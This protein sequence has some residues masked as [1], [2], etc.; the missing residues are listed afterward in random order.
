M[1]KH[2]WQEREWKRHFVLRGVD[3]K[4]KGYITLGV[5]RRVRDK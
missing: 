3:L 5:P 1:N 4:R 2:H